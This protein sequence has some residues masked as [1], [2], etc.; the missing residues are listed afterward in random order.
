MRSLE[1]STAF[2]KQLYI[3]A[4][5]V[6]G[7]L[8]TAKVRITTANVQ[9]EV[10]S[11][12]Q[13]AYQT[14]EWVIRRC[15]AYRAISFCN[16]AKPIPYTWNTVA[17]AASKTRA[18]SIVVRHKIHNYLLERI[19]RND[20]NPVCGVFSTHQGLLG[21]KCM[22]SYSIRPKALAIDIYTRQ[23][24]QGSNSCNVRNARMLCGW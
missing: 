12:G 14:D 18:G 6:K 5:N 7:C 13:S 8:T 10:K 23:W 9:R 2:Q 4:R 11:L 21:Q 22:L 19:D 20:S 24:I 1:L 3:H 15:I 16:S 17:Y